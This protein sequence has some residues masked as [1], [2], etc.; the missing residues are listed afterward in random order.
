MKNMLL[1][2]ALTVSTG[3]SAALQHSP[4]PVSHIA[5]QDTGI[6][7]AVVC[8]N[9]ADAKAYVKFAGDGDNKGYLEFTKGQMTKGSCRFLGNGNPIKVINHEVVLTANGPLFIVQLTQGKDIWWASANYFPVSYPMSGIW[10]DELSGTSIEGDL[11]EP[12]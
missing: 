5:Y 12:E 2:L 4:P 11:G 6:E 10:E 9:K 1:A 8:K 3:C 7:E